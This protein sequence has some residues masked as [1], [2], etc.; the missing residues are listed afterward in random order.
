[1]T[2]NG[3]EIVLVNKLSPEQHKEEPIVLIT[4]EQR[5]KQLRVLG[6]IFSYGYQLV[7]NGH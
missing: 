6:V 7:W 3:F 4:L 2:L 5:L 1:M